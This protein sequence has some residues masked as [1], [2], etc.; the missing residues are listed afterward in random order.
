[1]SH[2]SSGVEYGL[3]CL[4]YL[5]DSDVSTGG[6]SVRDLAELQ[7]VP[8]DFLAK[9]FTKLAKAEIVVATEGIKGGFRLARPAARI[10]VHDVVVAIDGEKALFDCREIR[11]RC[12][13]FGDEAPGWAT[14]GV[15]SIHAVMQAAEKVMRSELKRHTLADL[16]Q[17]TESKAPAAFGTQVVQW[18]SDRAAN[19]RGDRAEP[20]SG[21]SRKR[22]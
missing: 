22:A 4:L 5:A 21:R 20:V 14:R 12:A 1:M 9:L 19:R 7:G 17:R 2:I 3:H 11:A 13:I 15:C 8:A 18:L 16:A 10:T 6:A